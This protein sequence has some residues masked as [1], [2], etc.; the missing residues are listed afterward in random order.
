MIACEKC[1]RSLKVF[2]N[3]C[4]T[5]TQGCLEVHISFL[6]NADKDCSFSFLDLYLTRLVSYVNAFQIKVP[7]FSELNHLEFCLVFLIH[8][9]R[10]Q[11]EGSVQGRIW[12]KLKKN[13]RY[14]FINLT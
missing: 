11:A 14:K 8:R 3:R 4:H 5:A 13:E 7:S 1:G 9:I 2:G 12:N 6:R 10:G